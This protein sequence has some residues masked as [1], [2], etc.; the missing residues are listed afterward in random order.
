MAI[1]P[2]QL[3]ANLDVEKYRLEFSRTERVQ[4]DP[5]L[6]ADSASQLHDHLSNRGD[7]REIINSGDKVFELDRENQNKLGSQDRARLNDAI[8]AGAQTGFQHLYESIRV[9]DEP[10]ERDESGT[11]L[12]AFASFMASDNVLDVLRAITALEEINFADA[13]ATLYRPGDFLTAHR[14]DV[15]GKNRLAAYVLGLTPRWRTEWGGLLLFHDENADVSR[16]L[17]PR[18]NCLNI[19]RV[20]QTHSVSQVASYAGANR[21]SVT[22]WLRKQ[23]RGA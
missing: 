17:T 19:F 10:Q 20:P 4:I 9:S 11:A 8:R 15:E 23:D 2:Y 14:D 5:F 1:R 13:Q 18:F 16:G 3:A 21:V 6:S 12:D 7:W 22:G